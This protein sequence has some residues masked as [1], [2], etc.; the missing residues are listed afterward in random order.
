MR[1][2]LAGL[3]PK[4]PPTQKRTDRPQR[5]ARV[6]FAPLGLRP[7][8][9][10]WGR[11]R[12]REAGPKTIKEKFCCR[13]ALGALKPEKKVTTDCVARATYC[14]QSKTRAWGRRRGVRPTRAR[15]ARSRRS[16]SSGRVPSAPAARERRGRGLPEKSVDWGG[17]P[18]IS[19]DALDHQTKG[20]GISD[21]DFSGSCIIIPIVTSTCG[22]GGKFWMDLFDLPTCKVIWGGGLYT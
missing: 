14:V 9:R 7:A 5:C 6:P 19:G 21:P 18:R 12:G 20:C 13:V 1:E 10:A 2:S 8:A 15:S 11:R 17:D 16:T 3:S 4:V 22:W